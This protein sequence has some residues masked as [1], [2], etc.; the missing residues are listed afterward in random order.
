M[1]EL[2][3][4]IRRQANT[5]Y[6]TNLPNRRYFFEEAEKSLKQIKHTKGDGALA[7]LDIDHFK[8]N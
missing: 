2:I 7:M 1:L 6:L 8:V 4:T 3:A 5:D